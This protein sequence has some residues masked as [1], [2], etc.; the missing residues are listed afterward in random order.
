MKRPDPAS[1]LELRLPAAA[2]RLWIDGPAAIVDRVAQRMSQGTDLVAED[3]GLWAVVPGPG[4]PEVFDRAVELAQ[5]VI[6]ALGAEIGR[7]K[8]RALVLPAAVAIRGDGA[9]LLDDLLLEEIRARQPELAADV[10]HLTTHAALSMEGPRSQVTAGQLQMKGGRL[11]PLV[12]LGP[13]L[14]DVPPWRNPTVLGRSPRWVPREEPAATLAELALLPAARVLGPLGVGKTRLVQAV[15]RSGA[16]TALWRPTADQEPEPTLS[17]ALARQRRRPLWLV[18]DGLE[19]ASAAVWDEIDSVLRLR[20]LGR[21]LHVL[22][23]G[24]AGAPWSPAAAELPELHLDALEGEEWERVCE[25]LFHG[26]SLPPVVAERLADGAAGSPFA[27][28]EA[29]VHLV[30]DRQLRQV[31]GSFFFSGNESEAR[32][33]PGPRLRLHVEAETTRLGDPTPLRLAGLVEEPVPATELRAAAMALTASPVPPTW[34]DAYVAAGMVEVALGPWGDGLRPRMP[35]ITQALVAALTE[36]SVL[37]ARAT[38]GELLAARSG[39]AEE[40]WQ[41]WPLVAGTDE[42]ARTALAAVKSRGGST[43]E[44]QFTALRSEL[45]SLAERGGDRVLELELLWALLPIA[46]RLGRLHELERAID[47]GLSLAEDQPERFV[48]IA[49]VA[50]E[51]AQKEG[52][53]REAETVLRRALAA[54]QGDRGASQTAP[55]DRARARSRAA[56]TQGRGTRPVREDPRD[57]R[58]RRAHRDRGSQSVPARQPPLPRPRLRRRARTPRPRAGASSHRPASRRH[59]GVAGRP[60]SGGLRGRQLPRGDPQLRGGPR[61]ARGKR[62]GSRGVVGAARARAR[63]RPPRRPGRRAAR[64]AARAAVARGPRR[65]ARRG[66]R[67]RRGRR[68]AAPARAARSRPLLGAQ[69]PLRAR[70]A[71]RERGAGRGR[72]GARRSPPAPPPAGGGFDPLRGGRATVPRR[73]QRPRPAGGPR[74][75]ARGGAGDRERGRRPRRRGRRST[76]SASSGPS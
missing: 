20:D 64:A 45:A 42:G 40:L 37:R 67:A 61:G 4:H 11:L 28:E 53:L 49:A 56:R 36:E 74:R 18:Y 17:D 55:G 76:R 65:L 10:V 43:R 51:L 46:R 52:R 16:R 13:P 34:S 33:E 14:V 71:A 29:L 75:T 2:L 73:R 59:L 22:L 72:T 3:P 41:S 23:V 63:S 25:Q 58:A 26:L 66:D 24:R 9:R 39:S 5:R 27:L 57:R 8:A 54:G 30:R 48:A 68:D 31:F 47:R 15:L 32:F 62:C 70:V 50:A 1:T 12:T 35:A 60:R 6:S 44:E 69:G 19:S 38:L 21:G 7:G